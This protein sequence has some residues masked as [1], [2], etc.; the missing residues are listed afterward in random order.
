MVHHLS[1]LGREVD[2]VKRANAGCR[3]PEGLCRQI[4]PVPDSACFKMYIAVTTITMGAD[5]T[6]EIADHREGDACI[7]GEI[8][9]EAQTS[10]RNALVATPV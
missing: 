4:E 2:V 7:T 3:Q 10:G 1:L 8:L 9:P 6:V 5:G